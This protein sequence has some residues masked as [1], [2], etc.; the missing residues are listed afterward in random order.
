MILFAT[1]KTMLVY[2][3]RQEPPEA[4]LEP[5]SFANMR[6]CVNVFPAADVDAFGKT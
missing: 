6:T 4:A 3:P 5:A 1:R 2:S